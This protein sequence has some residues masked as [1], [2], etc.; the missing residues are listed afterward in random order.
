MISITAEAVSQT[1]TCKTVIGAANTSK[2][3]VIEVSS[4]WTHLKAF[5][6]VKKEAKGATNAGGRIG[7]LFTS[8]STC[9]ALQVSVFIK[10]RTRDAPLRFFIHFAIHRFLAGNACAIKITVQAV[11]RAFVAASFSAYTN[12]KNRTCLADTLTCTS[13]T[14]VKTWQTTTTDLIVKTH[15]AVS[16]TFFTH[17]STIIIK[18]S[19]S[20]TSAYRYK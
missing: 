17:R 2:G 20:Q 10:T 6:Q 14:Q 12:N 9:W 13:D 5:I 7:T 4:I 3:L 1:I 19:H 16:W 11:V 18:T 15:A 8:S